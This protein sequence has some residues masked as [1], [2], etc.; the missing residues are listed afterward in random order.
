LF[1]FRKQN[2]AYRAL[3]RALPN[4]DEHTFG[5]SRIP[6]KLPDH[7]FKNIDSGT[8]AIVPSGV[9]GLEIRHDCKC[10]CTAF[11]KICAEHRY[12]GELSKKFRPAIPIHERD[13]EVGRPFTDFGPLPAF[14]SNGEPDDVDHL[15][16]VAVSDAGLRQTSFG[17]V[18][19]LMGAVQPA[20]NDIHIGK[21]NMDEMLE[22][23]VP[24]FAVT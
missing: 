15:V 5:G 12:P 16:F 3:K 14:K 10:S 19:A 1:Q 4:S 24:I 7:R 8:F 2:G 18:K 11:Q 6:L 13:P 21:M 9:V 23:D 17:R 22:V 20:F